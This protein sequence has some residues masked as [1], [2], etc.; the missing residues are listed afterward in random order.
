MS[1]FDRLRDEMEDEEETDQPATDSGDATADDPFADEFDE[2]SD[3]FD[4]R[5]A[6]DD[7]DGFGDLSMMDEGRN[8]YATEELERRVDDV[9][10]ELASIS[11][12][13]NTIR[14]ENEEISSTVDDVEEN[15]RKLL[16]VYE[17]VTR[18]INPFTDDLDSEDAAVGER[19]L[20]LF[21]DE[22]EEEETDDLDEEIANADADSFFDD[23]FDEAE[24]DDFEGVSTESETAG[25]DSS[26]ADLK[27]EYESGDAGWDEHETETE[28]IAT[29][30]VTAVATDVSN[31]AD[32]SEMDTELRYAEHTLSDGPNAEKPYLGGSFDGYIADLLVLEWLEYLVD[33]AGTESTETAIEYYESI[34]WIDEE[35]AE[36]LQAFMGGFN[37][38]TELEEN[39]AEASLSIAHHTQSL[40]Y[41]CQL[42]SSTAAPV[43][44][45]G[46]AKRSR[47]YRR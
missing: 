35:T 22:A 19:S 4:S 7:R 16:D 17:M 9:E 44:I 24:T 20:G 1:L 11:S 18:G 27:A 23:G 43:V 14:S 28:T 33:A 2:M 10:T 37:S 6:L 42:S 45:D 12:T 46:W 39:S 25:D 38:D 5:G 41:I 34:R 26:F 30:S 31:E 47:G 3:E 15:V 29:E 40:R 32:S 13:V 36:H 21:E 8:E